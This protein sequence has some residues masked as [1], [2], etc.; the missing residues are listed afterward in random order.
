MKTVHWGRNYLYVAELTT[1]AGPLAVVVK[2]FRNQRLV[3]RLRRRRGTG[4]AVR[5]WKMA[6]ALEAAGIPT[7]DPVMLIESTSAAGPSFFVSR[8]L[9]EA[10]EARYL[11]RA[12][13]A[14]RE[15]ELYPDFDVPRVLEDLGRTVRRLH[16]AGLWHR[17]L[18]IGNVLIERNGDGFR[19]VLVDL[20]RARHQPHLS[21]WQRSRDLARLAIFKPEQQ[22][23]FLDAYWGAGEGARPGRRLAYLALHHGFRWKNQIKQLLRG[24]KPR[25]GLAPRRPHAHI[26]EAPAAAAAR[27]RAVWDRLSDQPHQHA[28]R[29]TKL[30]VRLSDAGI[31]LEGYATAAAALPR[32]LG[33]YRELL[34]SAAR[35]PVEW[36]GAGIGLRPWR[37][38]PETLLKLLDELGTKRVLL[39]LHPWEED[40]G[41]LAAEDDL[42]KELARRGCELT[43]AVPQNRDLV[44]DPAR[45]RAALAGIAER[46]MP[47]G[48][49]F[50]IG[51]AINRSKWGVWN[52]REYA[53]LAQVAEEVLRRSSEVE[54]IG[55]AVIDFEFHVTAAVLNLRGAGFRFDAVSSLLYVDRRG[56]PE[57]RQAGFDTV[58]KVTLL[59]AIAETARN[60][61][62]R[63]WITE[64]NWPLWE[65]PHS[66]AGRAVSV[67]EE[68]QADY[69]TRYFLLAFGTGFVE[70]IFWWQLVARGYGLVDPAVARSP[71]RRP[72]FAALR[73]QLELL[74]GTALVER[75]PAPAP[76]H[77]YQFRR[78]DGTELVVG[79]S[80]GQPL[81]VQ[82]PRPARAVRDRAG[83][84]LPAEA[85][86]EVWLE[87]SPRYFELAP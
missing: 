5:S 62:P 30:A 75:P 27:D 46:F 70:R 10:L 15:R 71:R 22:A 23:L 53:R 48:H 76:A 32:I 4:K 85:T 68:R 33:R 8:Y 51:Q 84:S 79:W 67:D 2:Q 63:C 41:E 29:L 55:P 19:L 64:V 69:L 7:A 21:T 11:L 57:N 37:E 61:G 78:P 72:S 49:R 35:T 66:P 25:A 34:A 36:G 50:Q 38:C 16:D 12:V 82:L 43:F 56:A 17:D 47:Y 18:S 86:T 80:T 45:Y 87:G 74:D 3:D 6:C 59:R 54:L 1:V 58:R 13:N 39:R 60:S 77:L 81:R 31:H 9:A 40:R 83:A 20:N 42:A 14:G 26:P 73:T 44:R 28:S 65:G 24:E 52:L